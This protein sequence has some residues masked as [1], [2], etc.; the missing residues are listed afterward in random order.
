MLAIP[1]PYYHGN[2]NVD[3]GINNHP[4]FD[5]EASIEASRIGLQPYLKVFYLCSVNLNF[6]I[7]LSKLV[8]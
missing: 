4:I 3:C 5:P 6:E 7:T 8:Q 1:L 2:S